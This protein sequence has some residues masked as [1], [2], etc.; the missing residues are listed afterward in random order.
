LVINDDTFRQQ[1]LNALNNKQG[2]GFSVCGTVLDKK[3]LRV[4]MTAVFGIFS[5]IVPFML[6]TYSMASS[7]APV[8]S[9]MDNSTRI[10]A[11]SAVERDY[12]TSTAFCESLW[13]HIASVHSKAKNEA[14]VQLI[15]PYT[16]AWVGGIKCTSETGV[17]DP[18]SSGWNWEDGSMYDYTTTGFYDI[19]DGTWTSRG[20]RPGSPRTKGL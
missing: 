4:M 20:W 14:I 1:Y 15:G 11:H 13:M 3:R 18:H 6:A 12:A 16:E 2:L 19:K 7:A 5:T 10:F 9:R 8:Y 17:S